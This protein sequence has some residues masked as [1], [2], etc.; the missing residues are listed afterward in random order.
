MSNNHH[1]DYRN[2]LQA[3][4]NVEETASSSRPLVCITSG[5]TK[6][7][8][9]KNMVRFVDNFSR[10]ERGATS[11]EEFLRRGYRVIFLY[12]VGSFFPFTGSF[13]RL[14]SEQL[15]GSFLSSFS[16]SSTSDGNK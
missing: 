13:R 7:P 4:L 16:S 5:G 15:D 6:V 9:E 2:R 10:G 1:D 14:V 11:A 8:L 12:R 3:F